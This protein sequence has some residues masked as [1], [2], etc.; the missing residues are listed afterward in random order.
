MPPPVFLA[1]D[2]A[3]MMLGKLHD[4]LL[5]RQCKEKEQL[6]GTQADRLRILRAAEVAAHVCVQVLRLHLGHPQ[7][8]WGLS[9]DLSQ[10]ELTNQE[11]KLQEKFQV[12]MEDLLYRQEELRHKFKVHQPGVKGQKKSTMACVCSAETA[13]EPPVGH[14]GHEA[15]DGDE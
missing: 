3:R 6:K 7:G 11:L 14:C 4:T 12:E 10:V 13:E 2:H 5:D 1:A 8:T 9:K 15:G